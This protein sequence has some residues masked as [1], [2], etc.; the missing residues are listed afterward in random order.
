MKETFISTCRDRGHSVI[1]PE[2]AKLSPSGGFICGAFGVPQTLFP[3]SLS[4][5]AEFYRV[6]LKTPQILRIESPKYRNFAFVNGRCFMF[7]V[8]FHIEILNPETL[9]EYLTFKK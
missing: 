7:F 8:E 5:E 3:K 9:I 2:Y 4:K 1:G 6:R